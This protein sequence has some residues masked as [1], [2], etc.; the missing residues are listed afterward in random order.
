MTNEKIESFKLNEEDNTIEV[1][2]RVPSNKMYAV[3]PPKPAPDYVW[4][5]IYGIID[6]KIQ[7]IK[8]IDGKHIPAKYND[9]QIIF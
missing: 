5:E 8:K 6:N 3:Y 1:V 7:L 4:K 9:E 2:K